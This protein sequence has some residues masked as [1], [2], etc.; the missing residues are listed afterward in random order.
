MLNPKPILEERPKRSFEISESVYYGAVIIVSIGVIFGLI[1]DSMA[2]RVFSI[3]NNSITLSII[4]ISQFI[5]LKKAI[6]KNYTLAMVLY[7]SMANFLIEVLRDLSDPRIL[8]SQIYSSTVLTITFLAVSGLLVDRW[9]SFTVSTGSY[10]YLLAFSL[11]IDNPTLHS[12]MVYYALAIFGVNYIIYFYRYQLS[13]FINELRRAKDSEKSERK[14]ANINR[15]KAEI[16]LEDLKTAQRQI[17]VQEKMASLGTLTA[18]IAHEIKNPL[19]FIT[20]FSESSSELIKELKTEL[21]KSA[22]DK[23][24]V[25]FLVDELLD[26]MADINEH[27]ERANGIIKSMLLHS[28]E[29]TKQWSKENI[30]ELIKESVTLVYHGLKAQNPDFQVNIVYQIP[31]QPIVIP[32]VRP[33]LSRVIL[34]IASNGFY[35]SYKKYKEAEDKNFTPSLIISV[36]EIDRGMIEISMEDNGFGVSKA[37]R[38][39]IFSPFFTTK[40]SGEGTGLGLSISY[41]IITEIHKGEMYLDS[42]ENEFARFVIRLPQFRII[43]PDGSNQ[44]DNRE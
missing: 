15:A 43:S 23:E 44:K 39:K 12:R 7:S 5:Y 26:N 17:I 40:P 36:K 10:L 33:D 31:S 14:K 29:G 34:N 38:D 19:N 1:F 9:V 22:P 27:G 42:V 2:G 13:G 24:E 30:S 6:G 11:T 4:I 37:N 21:N 18:G 20:N 25:N 16:A 28:R 8:E 35:S 41:E 32:M 3:V